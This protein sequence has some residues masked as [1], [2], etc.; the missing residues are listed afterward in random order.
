MDVTPVHGASGT[1]RK[2]RANAVRLDELR[3]TCYGLAARA[4]NRRR[5]PGFQGGSADERIAH[6]GTRHARDGGA[7]L[8]VGASRRANFGRHRH[9]RALLPAVL[10]VRLLSAL[11]GRPGAGLLRP[12]AGLLRPNLSVPVLSARAGGLPGPA[13]SARP[14]QLRLPDSRPPTRPPFDAAP[15]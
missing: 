6:I 15:P 14:G 9:R 13:G 2:R 5:A 7:A 4:P 8:G 12:A 10:P 11:R 3:P 1:R